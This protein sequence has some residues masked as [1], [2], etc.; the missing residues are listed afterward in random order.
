MVD[1]LLSVLLAASLGVAIACTAIGTSMFCWLAAR[2]L[3]RRV[4]GW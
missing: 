2:D 3:V 4:R 1:F